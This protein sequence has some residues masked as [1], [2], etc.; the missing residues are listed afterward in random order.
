MPIPESQIE[1]WSHRSQ[2]QTAVKAHEDIRG[3]LRAPNSPFSGID[4]EDYLQ[5]SYN[6][7]TRRHEYLRG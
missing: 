4:F 5:G 2:T 1:T 3:V 7:S 6:S